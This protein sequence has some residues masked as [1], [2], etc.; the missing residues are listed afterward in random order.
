MLVY[1]PAPNIAG[2]LRALPLEY[3]I[4]APMEGAI[5]AQSMAA[6][7]TLDFVEKIGFKSE[8]GRRVVNMIDFV[9]G[10]GK[11]INAG[12]MKGGFS[13]DTKLSIP[14][15]TMLPIPFIRLDELKI[16]FDFKI[17]SIQENKSSSSS[18]TSVEMSSFWGLGPTVSGSYNT[19][20]E[21]LDSTKRTTNMV[22][23]VRAVQDKMPSGLQNILD[24]FNEMV[25]TQAN[26]AKENTDTQQPPP[27]QEPVE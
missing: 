11:T 9:Y 4:A 5:K 21:N 8:N 18:G 7:H 14:M 1:M 20:Q 6:T 25:T 15:L 22:I 2:E 24:I 12:S 23:D 17:D 27:S 26:K 19:A 10:Q 3:I 13:D 16:H